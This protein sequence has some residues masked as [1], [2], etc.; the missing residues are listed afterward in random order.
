MI[1]TLS[2]ENQHA[3]Q[4][5]LQ[6]LQR[7]FTAEHGDLALE[8]ID[9][10]DT[11]AA[12]F[13]QAL[14]SVPFLASKKMVVLRTPSK[15]AGFSETAE[16]LLANVSEFTEV[17][18]VE[19]KLDKRLGYYKF[20][21]TQTDFRTYNQLPEHDLVQW[22]IAEAKRQK[23]IISRLDAHYL[24][25]R[26]GLNQ[27]L[28]TGEL[29]KILLYVQAAGRNS[30]NRADIEAL[31]S[32][33]PQSTI[34]EMI[35][36]AFAGRTGRALKLYEEQRALKVEPQQIV[37]MLSWQLHILAL[38]KAAGVNRTPDDI[39]K[40]AKVSPYVIKKN[41]GTAHKLILLDLKAHVADL[42]NIDARS[43]R[44]A[45]NIDDAL[46]LYIINLAK[47]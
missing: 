32:A 20:L 33:N 9:G 40:Q 10:D 30:I 43:K 5:A 21:H 14:T 35:D 8:R 46:K 19:P 12:R 29:T 11:D 28:L 38:I 4:Y 25:E 23:I 6:Q 31:T 39:A 3:L 44:S 18:I 36:A 17:I 7:A 16:Q 26:I 34:F 2:G 45:L 37:A 1:V 27:Q 42:V 47:R 15:N 22:L 13:S 41:M 24:V